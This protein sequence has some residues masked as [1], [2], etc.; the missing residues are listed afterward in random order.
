MY[1]FKCP[2]ETKENKRL[3]GQLISNWSRPIFNLDR[4]HHSISRDERERRD[5]D[6]MAKFKRQHSDSS[7]GSSSKMLKMEERLALDKLNYSC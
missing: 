2:K 5:L 1:L 6:H 3:A 7:E 4:D